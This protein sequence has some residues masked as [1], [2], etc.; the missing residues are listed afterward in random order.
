MASDRSDHEVLGGDAGLESQVVAAVA[1][2]DR[3]CAKASPT[4]SEVNLT[5]G[6]TLATTLHLMFYEHFRT[7]TCIRCERQVFSACLRVAGCDRRL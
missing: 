5:R 6:W 1:P 3:N 7:Q 2:G 4:F